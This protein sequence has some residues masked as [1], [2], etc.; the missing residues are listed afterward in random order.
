MAGAIAD[1]CTRG[2]W[3][4]DGF[5]EDEFAFFEASLSLEPD[6]EG[7]TV[8]RGLSHADTRVYLQY[9]R[10]ELHGEPAPMP[11][12]IFHALHQRHLDAILGG[13]RVA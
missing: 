3:S 7:R 5:T 9:W 2:T 6:E 10:A 4:R 11:R 8:L 13:M 1:G 12:S